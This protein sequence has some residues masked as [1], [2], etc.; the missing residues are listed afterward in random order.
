MAHVRMRSFGAL[1]TPKVSARSS[2]V[3][4]M[5]QQ[6][7]AQGQVAAQV[8]DDARFNTP[9]LHDRCLALVANPETASLNADQLLALAKSENTCHT[10]FDT[11]GIVADDTTVMQCIASP[12]AFISQ[13]CSAPGAASVPV[14]A[15]FI[16]SQSF[17][18]KHKTPLLIGGGVA[19]LLLVLKAVL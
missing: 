16:S 12:T 15:Q 8:C 7:A 11:L 3:Q 5:I 2:F 17:F 19:A 13:A 9:A 1:T 18:K 10:F 14:C 6:S 4:S